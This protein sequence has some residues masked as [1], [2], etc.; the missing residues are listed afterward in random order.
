MAQS[1]ERAGEHA[2][3]TRSG[4]VQDKIQHLKSRAED[5]ANTAVEE[6][7]KVASGPVKRR[8]MR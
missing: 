7:T 4:D 2:G 3:G 8:R 5:A 6:G 1:F